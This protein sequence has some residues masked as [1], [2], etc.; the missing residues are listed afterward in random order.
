[1]SRIPLQLAQGR[2]EWRPWVATHSH[3]TCDTAQLSVA[4]GHRD[5]YAG[6]MQKLWCIDVGDMRTLAEQT[7]GDSL[8]VR[9]RVAAAQGATR[10]QLRAAWT[11]FHKLQWA[12]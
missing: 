3:P 9:W 12:T 8:V 6:S 11:I 4:A 7:M 10:C 2:T 1:M 5:G